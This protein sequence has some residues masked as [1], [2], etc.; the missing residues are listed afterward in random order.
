[1][2]GWILVGLGGGLHVDVSK[3][4]CTPKSSILIGFSIINHPF[5]VTPIFG[6]TH[7]LFWLFLFHNGL[8]RFF[9]GGFLE[10]QAPGFGDVVN[11]QDHG[12]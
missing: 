7:V 12:S 11:N 5:W 4:G 10:D 8:R 2:V 3:N 6:N 9:V 1:M